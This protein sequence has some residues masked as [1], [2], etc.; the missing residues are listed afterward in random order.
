MK[1]RFAPVRIF[2]LLCFALLNSVSTSWAFNGAEGATFLE[3]PVGAG[4]AS[5]A[6]AYTP[7]ATD[8]YAPVWNPAGLGFLDS[9]QLGG[10]HQ[11]YID[12]TAF[13]FLSFV[14]PFTPGHAFGISA[15]Y[16][17]PSDM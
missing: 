6:G 2:A 9:T 12:Q 4:P 16:F 7:L 11:T 17:R 1:G 10:M 13:E 5:L 8:V 3:V 15:Q 14:H